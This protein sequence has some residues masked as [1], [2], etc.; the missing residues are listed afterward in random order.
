MTTPEWVAVVFLAFFLGGATA[1]TAAYLASNS[2]P[3]Q[4]AHPER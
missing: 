1:S 4:M 3:G 2:Q